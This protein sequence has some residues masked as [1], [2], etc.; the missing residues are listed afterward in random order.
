MHA[1]IQTLRCTYAFSIAHR[2]QFCVPECQHA[3]VVAG[4]HKI[5]MVVYEKVYLC[6]HM[7]TYTH[8]PVDLLLDFLLLRVL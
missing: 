5:E 1:H 2:H 8:I 3:R 6:K 7:H 4:T